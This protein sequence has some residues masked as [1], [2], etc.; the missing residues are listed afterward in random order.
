MIPLPGYEIVEQLHAGMKTEVYRAYY[1]GE[2]Q[3]VIIKVLSDEYPDTMDVAQMRHEY[4]ISRDL[5]FE[6]VVPAQ[7]LEKFRN[8]LALI[9]DD[10]GGHSLAKYIRTQPL[11]LG[12]FFEIALQLTTTLAELHQHHI[13]HRDIKPDNIVIVPGTRECFFVDFSLATAFTYETQEYCNPEVLEGTLY[14]I[15]PEQTG[16]MNRAIDYRTDFYSLGVTFYEMLTGHVPF[17]AS[18]PMELIH[19]HL[20]KHPPPPHDLNPDVPPAISEIVLKL[21]AKTAEDRYQS[22]SG[23]KADL[24]E[25][26]RQWKAVGRVVNFTPG[27]QDR[28]GKLAISS[29]L[30]GREE[31]VEL[32]KTAF[33][34]TR[35]G[36]VQL[37]TVSG[38]VG[39]GKS[40]LA[41]HIKE[42][43][44]EKGGFYLFGKCDPQEQGVPY[45]PII[46]GF[47]RLVRSLLLEHEAQLETWKKRLLQAVGSNGQMLIDV[48]PEL[49]LVIGKQPPVKESAPS[50]AMNRFQTTFRN[51]VNVFARLDHPLVLFLD[52]LQWVDANT[53]SLVQSLVADPQT[54]HFLLIGAYRGH[55]VTSE[56][57]WQK[58][59]GKLRQTVGGF[60][61][62]DLGPL[63]KH[64]VETL[65]Q[66]SLECPSCQVEE[67]TQLILD[68][69]Q[70]NP[71]FT[72][73]YLK[74]FYEENLL[75]FD[76]RQESWSWDIEALQSLGIADNVAE[77]MVGKLQRLPHQVLNIL[78]LASTIGTR[79]DLMTL[80]K[81][82][83]K[84]PTETEAS[85]WIAMQ[86]GMVA[87]ETEA[88]T[89]ESNL[90]RFLHDRIRQAAYSM[91]SEADKCAIHLSIGRMW[92]EMRKEDLPEECNFEVVN[93]WNLGR[94]LIKNPGE[95]LSLAQLNL[96]AGQKA[97][98]STAF[99]QALLYFTI[100]LEMLPENR[101][102]EHYDLTFVL[103]LERAGCAYI[104]THFDEAEAL[105]DELLQ[106]ARSAM[107]KIRVYI[108]R[109]RLYTNI[110]QHRKSVEA[111]LE[112]LKVVGIEIQRYSDEELQHETRSLIQYMIDHQVD[113]RKLP[114]ATDPL[115]IATLEMLTGLGPSAWVSDLRL[116]Q[117]TTLIA[118]RLCLQY[119]NTTASSLHYLALS[120][121]FREVFQDIEMAY[122]FGVQGLELAQLFQDPVEIGRANHVFGGFISP[123]RAHLKHS[124]PHLR[125]AHQMGMDVGD[126]VFAGYAISSLTAYLYLADQPFEEVFKS[127]RDAL[128]LSKRSQDRDNSDFLHMVQQIIFCWEGKTDSVTSLDG[129]GMQ[130]QEFAAA[131]LESGNLSNQS[132]YHSFKLAILFT[133]GH[134]DDAWKEIQLME[135][136]NLP[137]LGVH[138]PAYTM[139]YSLTVIA[140]YPDASQE[141]QEHYKKIVH[142]NRKLLALCAKHCPENYLHKCLVVD[143]EWARLEKRSFEAMELYN[144][145]IREAEE[146][147]FIA[148]AALAHELAAKFQLDLGYERYAQQHLQEACYH[149]HQWGAQA[150]VQHL[151]QSYPQFFHTNPVDTERRMTATLTFRS[152]ETSLGSSTSELDIQA[153]MKASQAIS[154]E[155]VLSKLL[156][157][158]MKLAIENAGAEK[159]F[160]ILEKDGEFFVE[161][162]GSVGWD[163]VT[164]LESI[165]LLHPEVT[166]EVPLVPIKIIQYVALTQEPVILHD[167]THEGAFTQIP[168]VTKFHP[169]SILCLPILHKGISIGAIYL[170]NDL[171][172]GA[173]TSNRL[174]V[175]QLLA[176]QAAIS[177]E[178]ARL[179]EAYGRFVPHEFLGLLH[180]RRILDVELGDQVQAQMSVLFADIRSFTTLSEGM[181]PQDNFRFL[182]SYLK[183]MGPVIRQHGG[184]I[185]KYIGDAIMALFDKSG[186]DAVKAALGMLQNLLDYN[187]HR[188][189][190]GFVPIRVGLGIHTG[191]M[192]LGTI[193]EHNRMEGTVISDAVNLAA[194]LEGMT[195]QYGTPL[196]IS[197]PTLLELKDPSRYHTRFLDRVKAK[198][199][200]EPV[201]I[202]EVF[203]ADPPEQR[204]AKQANIPIFT[205]AWAHYK[206]GELD[207]ARILFQECLAAHPTDPAPQVYINRCDQM[208]MMGLPDDWD[209]TTQLEEK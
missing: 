104:T 205:K 47:Q 49:E 75:R 40:V 194:R 126:W 160:L 144:R 201:V 68:K 28:S 185:D 153:I 136:N 150:K 178:N 131:M 41:Q 179:Y 6:G 124:Y 70:G 122:E 151:E 99:E 24:K 43:V 38:E 202:Y 190:Q 123:W 85:L 158:M 146:N 8:R 63:E 12:E 39:I 30:Y 76:F 188:Q 72:H 130:E 101:W 195:K 9:F 207:E 64:Q 182:N 92:W 132:W 155:I 165:P 204:D 161:A 23:L 181:S 71:L 84:T 26:F 119:G 60:R 184:F 89:E 59:L 198:G 110:G 105:F 173:F 174:E 125:K 175:L 168:Y 1:N 42:W 56:H 139:W 35:L 159:G 33:Q 74:T 21:M 11:G 81:L 203:D 87:K 103:S 200:S 183:H 25:C 62:I 106:Y 58:A 138:I 27:Q 141:D 118:C 209:G 109:A 96:V 4:E 147:E 197:E 10:H 142:E 50:E 117:S 129:E 148:H 98:S 78:Q 46:Q 77:L 52:N 134:Y 20:A 15:S 196:L 32:L 3:T 187:Q 2:P 86:E 154:Q 208:E 16:R 13:I 22:A 189:S 164:I 140:L 163:D 157:K 100:G 152:G 191:S 108:L 172:T 95:R 116:A 18:E 133:Y 55:E 137:K 57:P 171:T 48:I 127:L 121:Y 192:M 143:A 111:G 5:V 83:G 162:E 90:Y 180:K 44:R 170:E 82:N 34:H 37:V 93:Q 145:A 45:L 69:T 176:S 14:Y 167:A 128:A 17:Q 114:K 80:A 156:K 169:K 19:S 36:P 7:R 79:F 29:R 73:M 186:E 149:Y 120:L 113:I 54:E 102:A 91:I 66:D 199:K 65:I 177:I 115:K 94:S 166:G 135:E 51:F 206:Q 31:E 107:E 97:K 88:T 67:L 53:T 193:G 112:G 61:H